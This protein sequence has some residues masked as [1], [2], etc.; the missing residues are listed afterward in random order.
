MVRKYQYITDRKT[1][2]SVLKNFSKSDYL[3]LDTEVYIQDIRKPDYQNDKVRLI[4]I[5]NNKEVFLFDIFELKPYLD[6]IL[7]SLKEL[8]EN[9][10][11]IGH[12]LNFDIKFLIGN[13]GIYPKIVFD[14][15]IAGKLLYPN[16]QSYSLSY[17]YHYLTKKTLD[18]TEQNSD[19]G[20]LELSE[21][22]LDYAYKDIT[23]LQEIFPILQSEI[24]SLP[25]PNLKLSGD[26]SKT[27]KI[28]HP[29]F[30]TELYLTPFFAQLEL[31]GISIDIESI[32]NLERSIK[33]RYS[34]IYYQFYRNERLRLDR[35]EELKNWL[36]KKF[37]I[38]LKNSVVS[39]KEVNKISEEKVRDILLEF[40]TLKRSLNKI[41]ELKKYSKGNKIFPVI[42]QVASQTGR[43][44]ITEPNIQN[45]PK[46]LK[47][48]IKA[49]N[50]KKLII[51]DYSQIELRIASEYAKEERMIN[52]FKEGKDL[53]RFTASLIFNKDYKDI[54]DDERKKAKAV[55]FGL[56]YGMNYKTLREYL[57]GFGVN[58]TESE[59]KQFIEKFFKSY[60]KFKDWQDRVKVKLKNKGRLTVYSL[61]GRRMFVKKFNDAINY[62]IQGTGSDIFKLALGIFIN[63]AKGENFEIKN[64]VHDEIVVEVEEEKADYMANLL[65][66]SMEKAG[67]IILKNVPVK[68]DIKIAKSWSEK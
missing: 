11:I 4:Q 16:L 62:P 44:Y 53:H 57:Y 38:K 18:K 32:N 6:Y 8:L 36:Q 68:V 56:I 52:A 58:I 35:Q 3:F 20:A 46:K 28:Y 51:A 21:K 59:A 12:Y 47:G 45:I 42:K 49:K 37:N 55:N 9:K 17:L 26:L 10:G 5:G 33:K 1:A 61:F 2:L 39:E 15:F 40:L 19:W 66:E 64:L 13:F 22:Q 34:E 30:L 24:N 14:T 23:V 27:F 63:K 43:I 67:S 60:P 25:K 65:K 7:P 41:E 29:V 31:K 54:T 50:G 48:I